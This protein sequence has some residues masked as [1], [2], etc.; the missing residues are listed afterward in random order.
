MLV[1][2]WLTRNAAKWN[3]LEGTNMIRAPD[4]SLEAAHTSHA[5]IGKELFDRSF[6]TAKT[7]W[8]ELV[9]S[10]VNLPHFTCAIPKEVL[11]CVLDK[12]CHAAKTN[13]AVRFMLDNFV[14][15]LVKVIYVVWSN[16]KRSDRNHEQGDFVRLIL[17]HD[18]IISKSQG[19]TNRRIKDVPLEQ[20]G[21]TPRMTELDGLNLPTI[22]GESEDFTNFSHDDN[23]FRLSDLFDEH[24]EVLAD[25]F[26]SSE[27]PRNLLVR[28]EHGCLMSVFDVYTVTTS[29][30]PYR[31]LT[32]MLS[33]PS[34][35]HGARHKTTV[36]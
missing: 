6:Y 29:I 3:F 26:W 14:K 20:G 30:S 22:F 12:I 34:Q 33:P 25:T 32:E 15:K 24:G 9:C 1:M 10:H 23:D 7:D 4:S 2:D 21:L 19:N 36:P 35:H 28:D 16:G 8:V 17:T 11:F 27:D 31:L 5:G 18:S 13:C